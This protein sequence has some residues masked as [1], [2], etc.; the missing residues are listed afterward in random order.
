M[1][2]Y[3]MRRAMHASHL[4]PSKQPSDL[5][6]KRVLTKALIRMSNRLNLS[7]QE[8]SAIVGLSSASFSRLFT[9]PN[10]YLDPASKE[11]QLAIL[12]LRLYRSLDALFGGNAKQCELWLRSKNKHLKDAP[13][14]LIQTIEGLILVIHYLDAM[15]GKN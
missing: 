5:E 12:L 10:T 8:L 14:H 6:K 13:I 9:K 1:K 4:K 3:E 11:G 7:R 2:T 15:R